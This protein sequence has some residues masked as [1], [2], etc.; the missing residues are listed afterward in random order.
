[1]GVNRIRLATVRPYQTSG[2]RS[3]IDDRLVIRTVRHVRDRSFG[4]V[5]RAKCRISSHGMPIAHDLAVSYE[6]ESG[7]PT[8]AHIREV[9]RSGSGLDS[10]GFDC[11]GGLRR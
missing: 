1:M 10:A 2:D 7:R 9:W 6:D 5:I 4:V 8:H 11:V 3:A